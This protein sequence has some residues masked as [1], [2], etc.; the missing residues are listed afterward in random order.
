[1][2]IGVVALVAGTAGIDGQPVFHQEGIHHRTCVARVAAAVALQ[3]VHH[4]VEDRGIGTHAI[5]APQQD[6]V[7]AAQVY[8]VEHGGIVTIQP[9]SLCHQVCGLDGLLQEI[10]Y[11]R[12]CIIAVSA[13]V[14]HVRA[15]PSGTVGHEGGAGMVLFP[16]PFKQR[17]PAF[18]Q[19]RA[20]PCQAVAHGRCGQHEF[21]GLV[22]VFEDEAGHLI[23]RAAPGGF[24]HLVVILAQRGGQD[25]EVSQVLQSLRI[26]PGPEEIDLADVVVNVGGCAA[27]FPVLVALGHPFQ[28][29]IGRTD[30]GQVVVPQVVVAHIGLSGHEQ[31]AGGVGCLVVGAV[32]II[33]QAQVV[34]RAV[35]RQT[36]VPLAVEVV[37]A[38][39]E[40]IQVGGV[41]SQV[42]FCIQVFRGSHV[43][44]GL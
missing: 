21:V 20:I 11:F 27:D 26:E 42:I 41:G 10:L 22:E 6:F 1:M 37:V 33:E 28:E 39:V 7:H 15:G 16:C 43:G 17:H 5:S 2:F 44:D 29:V 4:V 18:Q 35:R 13:E 24:A 30:G 36:Y 32:V 3:V 40:G 34:T 12:V 8:G 31:L 9:V 25:G 38:E 23:A 19:C 14:V